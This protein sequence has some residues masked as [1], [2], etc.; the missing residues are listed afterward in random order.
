MIDSRE[1]AQKS[2]GVT[3]FALFAP[4]C[5]SSHEGVSQFVFMPFMLFM[6]KMLFFG[7]SPG[8]VLDSAVIDV[9][10]DGFSRIPFAVIERKAIVAIPIDAARFCGSKGSVMDAIAGG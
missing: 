5:G 7:L 8:N 9:E 10:G 1:K 6:V 4:F 2:Q 3:I